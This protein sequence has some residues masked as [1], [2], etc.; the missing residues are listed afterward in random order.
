[1]YVTVHH[2][3]VVVVVVVVVGGG[4]RIVTYAPD[5]TSEESG[6]DS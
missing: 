6:L 4:G 2:S 3:V 1:M 5:W